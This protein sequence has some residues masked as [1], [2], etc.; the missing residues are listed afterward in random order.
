MSLL[1]KLE[2][3]GLVV[4]PAV[5]WST[6][7][8]LDRPA[9]EVEFVLIHWDAIKGTPTTAVYL[10]DNRWNGILYHTVIRRDG[11][12]DLLS[13]GHVYH[14]GKGDP[15]DPS[16]TS[17]NWRSFS[18]SLNYHPDEGPPSEAQMDSLY[19]LLAVYCEHFGLKPGDVYDHRWWAGDR[20]QD[21]TT[22]PWFDLDDIRSRIVALTEQEQQTV[23][24][25]HAALQ[26]VG[27]NGGF[28]KW[29][30]LKIREERTKP[31]HTHGT[32]DFTIEDVVAEVVR[33][34]E[35]G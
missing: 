10:G 26:E 27:S 32:A 29:A 35:N 18:V 3:A 4:R 22:K 8:N 7:S 6:S 34:L 31:L 13:Q 14:A 23:R 24:E 2:D 21:I 11:T 30:V 33:R 12:V 16:K 19:R 15:A 9:P 17:G 5:N 1:V 28:A 25:L 20:K